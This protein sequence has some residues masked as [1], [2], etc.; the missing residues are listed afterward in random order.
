MIADAILDCTRHG[1]V[2][3]DCFLGSG[4]T[5]IAAERTGRCCYGMELDALYADLAIRRWQNWTGEQAVELVSARTFGEVEQAGCDE[6]TTS[7]ER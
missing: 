7:D 1:D 3:I 2:V 6:G 4:T 5:L